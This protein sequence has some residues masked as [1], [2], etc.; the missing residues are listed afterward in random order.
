MAR[1]FLAKTS[2][3]ARPIPGFVACLAV[4]A[5]C[6]AASGCVFG[7]GG[8]GVS[9]GCAVTVDKGAEDELLLTWQGGVELP[10]VEQYAIFV[11]DQKI[12]SGTRTPRIGETERIP[13]TSPESRVAVVVTYLDGRM[14]T[15]YNSIPES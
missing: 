4:L 14:E 2:L 1:A 3:D 12:V 6:L 10:D 13:V 5:A 7:F 9:K 8:D 11:N 15:I